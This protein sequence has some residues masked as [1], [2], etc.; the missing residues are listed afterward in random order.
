MHSLKNTIVAVGLLGLSFVLYQLSDKKP[1]SNVDL[2]G[3]A[4]V[5]T[6]PSE[7]G[8]ESI[9]LPSTSAGKVDAGSPQIN[10][11]MPS[12][13]SGAKLQSP[14]MNPLAA[15]PFAGSQSNNTT[16]N[17][18][19]AP[20]SLSAPRLTQ[21]GGMPSNAMPANNQSRPNAKFDANLK[22]NQFGAVQPPQSRDSGLI[23][24]L[25]NQKNKGTLSSKVPASQVSTNSN[26]SGMASLSAAPKSNSFNQFAG[27]GAAMEK[28]AVVVAS[29]LDAI[30]AG[31]NSFGSSNSSDSPQLSF[32]DAWPKVEQL[33]AEEKFAD[34]LKLLTKFYT[35]SDLTVPQRQRLNGWLD[36]LA[37]KVIFSAEHHLDQPHVVAAGENLA[38]LGQQW[39]VPGQLIYNVNRTAVGNPAS[40]QP[41]TQLKQIKGPFNASL[42]M[43]SNTMT[44]YVDNMYAGRFPVK[45]GVSG[46]PRA[47]KF[48]VLLK[49]SAGYEWRDAKGK[50]YPPNDPNNGYGRH[51]MGLEGDVCI[52]AVD[53]AKQAGHLG[54][55]GLSPSDAKDVFAILS[56]GSVV[57][58]R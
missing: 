41:G 35:R 38:D 8:L 26:R 56:A 44:L 10:L 51:W 19:P 25:E 20:N 54:S 3:V 50:A 48:K 40:L 27:G 58:L 43:T 36:A 23:A 7:L 2:N 6:S 34:A 45:V 39:G 13:K 32:R 47:G 31:G 46:N 29:K 28:S 9:A 21:P 53:D 37:G 33:V 24:A 22:A 42:D 52:H 17:S 49:N 16:T 18:L 12:L 55:I 30:P 14:M 11:E 1:Q 57:T 5:V 15:K 4:Q